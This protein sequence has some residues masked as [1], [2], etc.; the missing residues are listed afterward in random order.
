VA[1]RGVASPKPDW[2]QHTS[3]LE[4]TLHVLRLDPPAHGGTEVINLTFERIELVRCRHNRCKRKLH[5]H[6]SR[7]AEREKMGCVALVHGF[8]FA[9][10]DQPL[11]GILANRL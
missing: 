5:I 1:F 3:A 8:C 2:K 9:R 7:L 11:A 10:L 4:R 6:C